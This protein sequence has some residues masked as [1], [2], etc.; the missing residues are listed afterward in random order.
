MLLTV[1]RLGGL[2]ALLT[3]AAHPE[4]ASSLVS[5]LVLTEAGPSGPETRTCRRSPRKRRGLQE[6]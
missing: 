1:Q 6:N 2:T 5:S 3:A 4:L